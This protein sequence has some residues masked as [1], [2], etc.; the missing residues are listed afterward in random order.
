MLALDRSATMGALASN[1][2]SKFEAIRDALVGFVEDT[3]STGTGL[4]FQTFPATPTSC[5]VNDDCSADSEVQGTCTAGACLVDECS[6]AHYVPLVDF[7]AALPAT[8]GALTSAL[9]SLPAPLSNANRPTGAGLAAAIRVARHRALASPERR[10]VVALVT[11]GLPDSCGDLA[12]VVA[13]AKSGVT[14]AIPIET[15]VVGLVDGSSPTTTTAA[16]D[17][18]AQAGGTLQATLVSTMGDV[19]GDVRAELNALR[20]SGNA[21]EYRIPYDPLE[22]IPTRIT[23]DVL[24]NG[25]VDPVTGAGTSLGRVQAGYVRKVEACDSDTGHGWYYD[26]D[27]SDH[28]GIPTRILMCPKTCEMAHEENANVA[29]SRL[30]YCK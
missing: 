29:I 18:I 15:Y 13:I 19:T 11:D 17:T 24:L 12:S 21:C 1:G 26:H 6:A 14:D 9:E 30:D 8:A 4:T 3:A 27:P 16:Y 20:S 22:I 25:P 28:G 23:V 5:A 10:V 7:G 2:A